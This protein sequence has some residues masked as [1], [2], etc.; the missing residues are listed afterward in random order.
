MDATPK[1]GFI[2]FEGMTGSAIVMGDDRNV[3]QCYVQLAG[4][5]MRIEA[6]AFSSV[7]AS[8]PTMRMFLLRYVQ[9][10]LIQTGCT[11]LVNARSKLEERLARWLLMCDDRVSRGRLTITHEFLGVMLGVRRPGV[12][13]ALQEL[14]GRGL[15]R[16]TR[17]QIVLLDRAGLIVLANGGYG[18]AEAEYERLIGKPREN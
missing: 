14:E 16:A 2:G 17:G 15:I 4:E 11:A 13:V 12:T 3:H 7:L 18:E 10:L 1:M 6:A 5:A 8:S 9:S